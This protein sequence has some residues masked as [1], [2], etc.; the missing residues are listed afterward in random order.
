VFSQLLILHVKINRMCAPV[1]GLS[2]ALL[3]VG[4]AR[5]GVQLKDA[6]HARR[7]GSE[8]KLSWPGCITDAQWYIKRAR[9]DQE[10]LLSQLDRPAD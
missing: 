10:I 4:L 2:L 9:I 7:G 6:T 5:R 8:A 1:T 3:S